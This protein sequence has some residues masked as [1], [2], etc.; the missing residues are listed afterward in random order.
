M[1]LPSLD[2]KLKPLI[3]GL[4]CHYLG[5]LSDE[6]CAGELHGLAL[7]VETLRQLVVDCLMQSGATSQ[8]IHLRSL[9]PHSS[10]IRSLV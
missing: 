9:I 8:L 7:P 5:A 1:P 10:Q 4:T 2:T 6:L 3:Q